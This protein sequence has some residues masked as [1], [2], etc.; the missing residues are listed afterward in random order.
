MRTR[1]ERRESSRVPSMRACPYELTKLDGSN[2]V[3]SSQGYGYSINTSPGG[4]LLLLPQKVGKRQ[5]FEVHLPA[6]AKKKQRTKLVEVRWTQPIPVSARLNMYL[7][8]TRFLF[9]TPAR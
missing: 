8:G 2:A 9:E 4:M 1:P 6:A 3:K 7:V 5:V